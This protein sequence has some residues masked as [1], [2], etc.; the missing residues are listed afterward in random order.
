MKTRSEGEARTGTTVTATQHS[1]CSK[2]PRFGDQEGFIHLN[3]N[4]EGENQ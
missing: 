3:G 2:V 4:E 1:Y